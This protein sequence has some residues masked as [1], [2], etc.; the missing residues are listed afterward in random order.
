[1]GLQRATRQEGSK[2]RLTRL[3][4]ALLFGAGLLFAAA[5][6]SAQVVTGSFS[7]VDSKEP[8]TTSDL[9]TVGDV[10]DL[11]VIAVCVSGLD[12]VVITVNTT[13]P[14]STKLSSSKA[15]V[16]Q[17]AKGNQAFANFLG[18]GG[19]SF[20][21]DV[22]GSDCDKA[23]V[24]GTVQPSKDTGKF[25]AQLNNCSGLSATQG[26]FVALVC[27]GNQSLKGKFDDTIGDIKKLTIT[28]KGGIL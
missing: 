4:I 25:K 28:G 6:A 1:M 8:L 5:G 19:L 3:G 14:D 2:I 15:N 9:T 16:A 20:D 22:F 7:V 13:H 24:N 18:S 12:S 21:I 23:T 17:K 27:S 26:A 11:D 10:T